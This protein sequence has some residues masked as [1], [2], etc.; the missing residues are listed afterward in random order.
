VINGEETPEKIRPFYIPI[1]L[2]TFEEIIAKKKGELQRE[3]RSYT[4]H[5]VHGT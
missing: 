4:K 3:L 2:L 5:N 1:C